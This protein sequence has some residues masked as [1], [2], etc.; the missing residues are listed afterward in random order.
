MVWSLLTCEDPEGL[1]KV[2]SSIREKNKYFTELSYS[3][4]DKYKF[5]IAS[6][7]FEWVANERGLKFTIFRFN[8]YQTLTDKLSS[9]ELQERTINAMRS[10]DIKGLSSINMKLENG[11]GPSDEFNESL[12]GTAGF[13]MKPERVSSDD[14]IQVN[15]LVSGT[16]YS[17]MHPKGQPKSELK[18]GLNRRFMEIFKLDPKEI[19][20]GEIGGNISLKTLKL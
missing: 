11:Y 3:S 17:I 8:D 16:L 14:F 19:R 2:I 1:T 15:D 6:S 7:L 5:D 10:F 4:N 9:K 18:A 12:Q 20:D 13:E